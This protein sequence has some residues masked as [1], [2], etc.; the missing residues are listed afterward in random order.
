ME[1][2]FEEIAKNIR[3]DDIAELTLEL[4]KIPSPTGNELEACK[5]YAQYLEGTG[6]EVQLDYVEENRPN[7]IAKI[8]G[9]EKGPN[10][11]LCGHLDTIPLERCVPPKIEEGLSLIHI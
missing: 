11:M 4:V 10:L 5:F 3:A 7:V 9:N 8:P 6:L 1:K 2:Q